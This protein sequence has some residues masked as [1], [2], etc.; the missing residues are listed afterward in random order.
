MIQQ[1][2]L[3]AKYGTEYRPRWTTIHG[4]WWSIIGDFK[5]DIGIE[6]CPEETQRPN[7][8]TKILPHKPGNASRTHLPLY[9]HGGDAKFN[10]WLDTF[11]TY[12]NAN[13]ANIGLVQPDIDPIV[14]AQ[15]DS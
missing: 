14:T 13:L 4:N 8:K 9:V 6:W 12:A 15:R 2:L 11:V 7:P 3:Y 5:K 1:S 10:A